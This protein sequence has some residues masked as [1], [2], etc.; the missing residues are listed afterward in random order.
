MDSDLQPDPLGRIINYAVLDPINALHNTLLHGRDDI[1]E[2]GFKFVCYYFIYLFFNTLKTKEG[3]CGYI[4]KKPWRF[5]LFKIIISIISFVPINYLADELG[6]LFDRPT[7][8]VGERY[9]IMIDIMGDV[10][11]DA[12]KVPLYACLAVTV[13]MTIGETS[14]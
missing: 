5:F 1:I 8:G 10:A 2:D 6:G 4:C 14:P 12:I 3:R 11:E 7:T 13:F 9:P